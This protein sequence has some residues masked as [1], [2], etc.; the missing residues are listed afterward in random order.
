MCRILEARYCFCKNKDCASLEHK[1]HLRHTLGWK[2]SNAVF[3]RLACRD[4]MRCAKVADGLTKVDQLCPDC[5]RFHRHRCLAVP[6]AKVFTNT[7][8][9]GEEVPEG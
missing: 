7:V 4:G 8:E 2:W 3:K 9:H 1:N 6:V 5:A